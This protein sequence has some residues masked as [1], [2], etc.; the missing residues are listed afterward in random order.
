MNLTVNVNIPE[1]LLSETTAARP[2]GECPVDRR[3]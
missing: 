3:N 1:K 2:L